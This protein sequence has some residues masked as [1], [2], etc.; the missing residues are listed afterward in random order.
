M[1]WSELRA[2]VIYLRSFNPWKVLA[3]IFAI[4]NLKNLPLVWHV[5]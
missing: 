5:R 4:L 1:R 2:L 3:I